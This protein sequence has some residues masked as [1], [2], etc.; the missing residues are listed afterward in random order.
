MSFLPAWNVGYYAH[1]CQTDHH[2]I[3]TAP[4]TNFFPTV[5]QVKAALPDTRLLVMNSPLNPTGTVIDKEVLRGIAQAMWMRTSVAGMR[6]PA[7]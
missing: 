7:C 6:R 4:E 5:D 3:G 1:L 2:F